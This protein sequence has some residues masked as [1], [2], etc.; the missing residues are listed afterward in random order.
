MIGADE[1]GLSEKAREQPTL[2][3]QAARRMNEM[4][5]TLLDFTRL[6]F[7]GS[8]PVTVEREIVRAPGGTIDVRSTRDLTTFAVR[9]PRTAPGSP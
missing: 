9:L 5:G 3:E 7:R 8:L 1:H 6:R 2:I 4:S